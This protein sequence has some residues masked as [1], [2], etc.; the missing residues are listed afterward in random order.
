MFHTSTPPA[1]AGPGGR[2]WLQSRPLRLGHLIHTAVGSSAANLVPLPAS[3]AQSWLYLARRIKCSQ[4]IQQPSEVDGIATAS[5]A[6][7]QIHCDVDD[8]SAIASRV[9]KDRNAPAKII[10]NDKCILVPPEV[11]FTA[12]LC[13]NH[14]D[15]P[16]ARCC[17]WQR[18]SL[19]RTRRQWSHRR[20]SLLRSRESGV[21]WFHVATDTALHQRPPPL[22][23]RGGCG[24][25]ARPCTSP[26]R[27]DRCRAHRAAP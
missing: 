27:T 25:C 21:H 19:R 7:G 6:I 20:A 4:M 23:R 5:G 17:A 8:I 11:I 12:L 13:F 9:E 15:P 18:R 26:R 2:R 14:G 22:S 16:L 10:G 1:P 24:S 3:S